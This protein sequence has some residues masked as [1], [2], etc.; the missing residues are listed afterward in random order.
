MKNIQQK[1]ATY[2]VF[3][4]RSNGKI[5]V[6]KQTLENIKDKSEFAYVRRWQDD[7]RLDDQVPFQRFTRG[8]LHCQTI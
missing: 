4:E 3:G 8:H 6:L 2:N 7:V 5:P 1:N